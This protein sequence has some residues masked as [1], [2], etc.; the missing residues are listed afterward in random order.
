MH[1]GRRSWKRA[2]LYANDSES[3]ADDGDNIDAFFSHPEVIQLLSDG[4]KPFPPPSPKSKSEFE[5]KTAAIHV[6]TNGQS[7]FDLKEIKADALWLSQQA[8]IDEIAALRITILEWQNRPAKRLTIGFSSE[9]ATSLQS[10]AGAENLRGSLAGPNFASLLSQTARGDGVQAFDKEEKRR[11]RLRE[12]YL[13]EAS[14]IVKTLRKLLVLSLHDAISA[15]STTFDTSIRKLALR[16]IGTKIFQTRSTGAGLNRFMQ[17]CISSIRSRLKSLEGDGGWLNAADSGEEM[18]NIWRTNIVEEIV[19]IV[20]I[21][22]HQ[23]HAS[24]EISD[25]DLLLSWL[26]LMA[27][28][29]F[30]EPIQVVGTKFFSPRCQPSNVFL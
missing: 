19:H 12:I 11:L 26:E 5:S 20:Q 30:L 28:Y 25:A 13:S 22:F 4:L 16:K 18:E 29:S 15:D 14:H 23:L 6:E 21:M 1:I 24:V 27:E 10:A 17:E 7:S 8:K 2:F 3:H 9:E